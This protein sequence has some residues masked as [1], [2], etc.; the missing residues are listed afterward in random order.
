MSSKDFQYIPFGSPCGNQRAYRVR[1]GWG[2]GTHNQDI[3][4]EDVKFEVSLRY[5]KG[6][7]EY[8]HLEVRLGA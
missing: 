3:H 8:L 4:F 5:V 1:I 6:A 2:Q 7:A